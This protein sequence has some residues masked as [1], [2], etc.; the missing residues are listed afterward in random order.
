MNPIIINK[1]NNNRYIIPKNI[2]FINQKKKN[3]LIIRKVVGIKTLEKSVSP[4]VVSKYREE[5]LK[6]K[7]IKTG[8]GAAADESTGRITFI[9]KSS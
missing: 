1:E 8:A 9:I 5:V 4:L 3:E 7:F 2:L 6:T